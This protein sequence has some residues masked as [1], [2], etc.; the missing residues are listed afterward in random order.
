M[1]YTANKEENMKIALVT[2]EEFNHIWAKLH[3]E[4]RRNFEFPVNGCPIQ[5]IDTLVFF[6]QEQVT[7]GTVLADIDKIHASV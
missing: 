1:R 3:P 6:D 5:E 2:R 4:E 7:A